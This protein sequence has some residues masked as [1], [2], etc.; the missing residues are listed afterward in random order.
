MSRMSA[1][2]EDWEYDVAIGATIVVP[3]LHGGH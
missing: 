3:A 2:A 1:C